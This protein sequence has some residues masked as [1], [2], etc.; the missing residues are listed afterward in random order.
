MMV[1]G[2]PVAS[3]TTSNLWRVLAVDMSIV[4]ALMVFVDGESVAS[5][6]RSALPL[7]EGL[8]TVAVAGCL[9]SAGLFSPTRSRRRV[10][11]CSTE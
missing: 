9:S 7:S 8:V 2:L 11:T 10:C 3:Q 1:R 5:G 4:S 6:I